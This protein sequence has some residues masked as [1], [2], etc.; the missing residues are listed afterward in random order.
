LKV[1]GKKPTHSHGVYNNPCFGHV[2]ERHTIKD[3]RVLKSRVKN[4]RSKKI[5]AHI[6]K[7]EAHHDKEFSVI[8]RLERKWAK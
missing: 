2:D 3:Y 5:L 6:I 8:E 7:D 4:P 1:C